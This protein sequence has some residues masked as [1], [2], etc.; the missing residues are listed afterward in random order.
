MTA[1]AQIV[2]R[3]SH[4]AYLAS[5]GAMSPTELWLFGLGG[6]PGEA[7]GQPQDAPAHNVPASVTPGIGLVAV[8]A[9]GVVVAGG[10]HRLGLRLVHD[11]QSKPQGLQP[12]AQGLGHAPCDP[13]SVAARS[14]A[15]CGARR[16]FDLG[17]VA[18]GPADPVV[19]RL[20]TD[21]ERLTAAAQ[22]SSQRVFIADDGRSNSHVAPLNKDAPHER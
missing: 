1:L 10:D 15:G 9:D 3:Q 20:L 21:A 13:A 5:T 17:A 12:P 18:V 6:F 19:Q 16:G 11:D 7:D 2:L 14:A 22:D 4:V 8:G